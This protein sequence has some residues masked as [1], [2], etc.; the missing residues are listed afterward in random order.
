MREVLL[1]LGLVVA[2][3]IVNRWVLPACGVST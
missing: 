1:V 2:W 3:F